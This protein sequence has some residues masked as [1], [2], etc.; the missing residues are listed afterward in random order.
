M[1]FRISLILCFIK[2]GVCGYWSL[3]DVVR[4]AFTLLAVEEIEYFHPIA[5]IALSIEEAYPDKRKID[6]Y[7]DIGFEAHLNSYNNFQ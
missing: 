5:K 3:D 1:Y 7:V 4:M 2:I 6:K